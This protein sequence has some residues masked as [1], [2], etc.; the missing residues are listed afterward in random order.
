M[1]ERSRVVF[2]EKENDKV[3]IKSF[4]IPALAGKCSLIPAKATANYFA[5]AFSNRRIAKRGLR[6]YGKCAVLLWGKPAGVKNAF[7]GL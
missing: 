3:A 2:P 7:L 6:T 1:M 5:P 4:V